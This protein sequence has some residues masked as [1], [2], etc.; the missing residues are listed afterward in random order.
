MVDKYVSGHASLPGTTDQLDA[1]D[2]ALMACA[3]AAP[4][5]TG[6][7]DTYAGFA[8]RDALLRKKL[9]LLMAVLENAPETHS[10]FDTARTGGR[11]S[12]LAG[13]GLLGLAW[14]GR[15]ALALLLFGMVHAGTALARAGRHG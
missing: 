11:A 15:L 7:A 6:V 1:L 10:F 8:R 14:G 4:W 12:T 5:L 13:I 3:S 9:V 2:R